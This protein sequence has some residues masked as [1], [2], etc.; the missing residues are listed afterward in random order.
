MVLACEFRSEPNHG[1]IIH[2]VSATLAR[3]EV[4][5]EAFVCKRGEGGA[6]VDT[7]SCRLGTFHCTQFHQGS[8][9]F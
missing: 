7:H 6:R 1:T 8:A 9:A 3:K 4:Y 2:L 5:C